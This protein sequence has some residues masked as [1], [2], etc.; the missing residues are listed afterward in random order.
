MGAIAPHAQSSSAIDLLHESNELLD[1]SPASTISYAARQMFL[2]C[3]GTSVTVPGP[4]AA[5]AKV[6]LTVAESPSP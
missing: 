1:A 5:A 3:S 6:W 2:I 4:V